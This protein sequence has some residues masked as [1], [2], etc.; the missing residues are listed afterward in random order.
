VGI[1]QAGLVYRDA[2]LDPPNCWS[3][4]DEA[5]PGPDEGVLA[6]LRR[7]RPGGATTGRL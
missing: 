4:R 5:R 3:A 1:D 7:P 2:E 6:R